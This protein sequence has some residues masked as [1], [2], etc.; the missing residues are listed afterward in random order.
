MIDV[1]FWPAPNGHKATIAL[2]ELG[3]P[4]SVI[5][6]TIGKAISATPSS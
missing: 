1:Y 3:L 2:Q 6:I 5:R 4:Y